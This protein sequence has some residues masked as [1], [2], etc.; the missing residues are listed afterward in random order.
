VARGHADV[1]RRA[2]SALN[3][4]RYAEEVAKGLHDKR[5][6]RNARAPKKSDAE[7]CLD[8]AV[9]PPV[10]NPLGQDAATLFAAACAPGRSMPAG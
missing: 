7:G 8:A 6:A 4:Q 10:R 1:R 2:G 5:K 3:H 9:T